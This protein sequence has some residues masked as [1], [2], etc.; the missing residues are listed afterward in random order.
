MV[1]QDVLLGRLRIG[2]RSA[3][4][5]LA[6][7]GAVPRAVLTVLLVLVL[8]FESSTPDP[9]VAI[10]TYFYR[11]LGSWTS[12]PVL[13]T[14]LEILLIV[15]VVLSLMFSA[16]GAPTPAR[17]LRWPMVAFGAALAFGFL[18]GLL[19][20]GDMYIGLWEVR[21]LLYVPASFVIVRAAIR[22]PEHVAWLLWSGLLAVSAFAVEGAYRAI[23]LIREGA[24]EGA[25]EFYY[26][27]E[28]V[29]FL[30]SFI[31]LVACSLYFRVQ[32]RLRTFGLLAG[33][34]LA[35]TL[36]ASNRRAGII[37]LLVALLAVALIVFTM[38]RKA[39]FASVVP[40][41]ILGVFYVGLFWNASG[42]MGQPARAIRSLYEPDPRDASSNLYRLLETYN[43]DFTI[44]QDPV[45]GVG[46]GREFI[47]VA[48]LADLSW[49]PFWRF[50][51]H[52]NVL[53]MWLK[54]GAVGYAMFWLLMG[55]AISRAAYA[56]RRLVD[57]ALRTAGLFCLLSVVGVIVFAW[58][59]LGLVSG[60]VTVFLGTV[61]GLVSVLPAV[62]GAR[63]KRVEV[64]R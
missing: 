7:G 22:R 46:F 52:N 64:R 56:A 17:P 51:T 23:V 27:H 37:V 3:E 30:A 13:V 58:V 9:L 44:H 18:R 63:P 26:E 12:I 60:R 45:L 40:V 25:P 4:I 48:T 15:G 32:T 39:F 8:L 62:D 1:A 24:L 21:Y 57:P 59:D 35:F 61:L 20:E 28:G 14:P 49:W 29:I 43:I 53:W 54:T 31:A 19:A 42:V 11:G 16:L 36:L 47:M 2:F 50:E 33:P 41:M 38:R 34:V 55:S 5:T 10:G 6:E